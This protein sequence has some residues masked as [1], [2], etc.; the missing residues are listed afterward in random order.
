MEK[1]NI[2][3]LSDRENI[4]VILLL[5]WNDISSNKCFWQNEN[6]VL[7]GSQKKNQTLPSRE[8]LL[9]DEENKFPEFMNDNKYSLEDLRRLSRV[10]EE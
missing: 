3:L 10:W 6:D 8:N 1:P 4:V 9:V 7:V 2:N 5:S